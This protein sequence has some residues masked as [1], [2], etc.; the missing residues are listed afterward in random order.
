MAIEDVNVQTF[1]DLFGTDTLEKS[2]VPAFGM[3][4]ETNADLFTKPI[5]AT[6]E[7]K[8]D[9][10]EVKEGEDGEI[11]EGDEDKG[12]ILGAG[13]EKPG[14]KPKYDFTDATGYFQDRFKSGKFVPI[15]Q[16]GEDG[17]VSAFVPKTPEEFDEVIDLQVSYQLNQKVK[18]LENNW[19]ASKSPAW[20][21]VAKYAELT[22][23]PADIV[24]FLQGVR[25]IESVNDLDP[26]DPTSA[27]KIVR[28]RLQQRG[29]DD[30]VIAEQ[31]EALKTTDK[32]VSAAQKYKPLILQEEKTQLSQMVSEKKAQEQEYIQ[33]VSD[34]RKGA[35]TAIES[36]I[37]GK[38]KLKQ[39]EKA[40]V[41]DMI[42]EPAKDT[43]GYKI[44][45]AIDELFSKGDYDKL[46]KIALILTKEEALLEYISTGASAETAKKLQTKLRVAGDRSNSTG[47]DDG[48]ETR[49]PIQRNQYSANPRFGR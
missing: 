8:E 41:Y 42:A 3:N 7:G 46:R 16:E 44:Y 4:S 9:T 36:P 45:S 37:F 23:D 29:D 6:E 47:G 24:P 12:D 20:Q 31:I 19:Y 26:T 34:I 13:G 27:E 32:L 33:M 2:S 18:E 43:G 49:T 11:K 1:G 15:E 38:Q 14:R 21:A 5:P 30:E 10:E 22:D 28:A 17:K 48:G 25:T 40:A 35:I 39:E